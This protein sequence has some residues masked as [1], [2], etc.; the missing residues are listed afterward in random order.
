MKT[1]N[2]P[3]KTNRNQLAADGRQEVRIS[4][5]T[6]LGNMAHTEE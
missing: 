5:K 3:V 6:K 4:N 1:I 2:T